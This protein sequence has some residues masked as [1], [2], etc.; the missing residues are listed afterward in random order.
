MSPSESS[1]TRLGSASQKAIASAE[2]LA[3]RAADD[4]QPLEGRIEHPNAPA[5]ADGG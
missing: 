4:D 2:G 5:D 3:L 1:W